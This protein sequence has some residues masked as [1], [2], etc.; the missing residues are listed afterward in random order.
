MYRKS[1]NNPYVPVGGLN[2]G[3]F[4]SI[5]GVSNEPGGGSRFP[6]LLGQ[7]VVYD[8]AAARKV[9]KTSVGILYKGAYQLVKF[10]STIT[11]GQLVFW[12]P[13]AL[14]G[15]DDY[16]VTSTVT[17]PAA[18][19]AGFA[20]CDGTSGEYG[21]I[22]IAGLASGLYAGSLTNATLGNL[23]IQSA[24]NAATLDALAD[25]GAVATA[26]AFKQIVGWAYELPVISV[27]KQVL[28]NQAGFFT[29]I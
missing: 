16:E 7:Y 20:I 5:G 17:A 3:S 15:L 11:R 14:D 28:M 9:S 26:G 2:A 4:A 25:A 8:N 12:N 10:V 21:W 13:Y 24:L 19:K 27:T 29:N 23:V 1:T 18:F 6:G 22:Q